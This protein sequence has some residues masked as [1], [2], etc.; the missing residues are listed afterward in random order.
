MLI[1]NDRLQPVMLLI[2][3][4]LG[5]LLGQINN[6]PQLAV[7]LVFPFL[8]LMLYALFLNIP[9]GQIKE[10]FQNKLFALTS[11]SINFIWTPILA[12][13]LGYF[14]LPDS[15]ALKIGFLMLMVTPCADWYLAF[16]AQA[17]GNLSLSTS[18][19]PANLL[20]QI[21]LLPTYLFLFSGVLGTFNWQILGHSILWGLAL[22]FLL[23][24][25]TRTIWPLEKY[26]G[27]GIFFK[28]AQAQFLN[29]AVMSM[30]AAE[31]YYLLK[32]PQSV[33]TLLLPVFCFFIITF[34]L[35]K[36]VASLLKFSYPDYVSLTMTT[37]ARNSPLA[38]A[39]AIISFPHEPLVHLALIVGPLLELPILALTVQ[40]LLFLRKTR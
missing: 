36:I 28:N 35:A 15:P 13:A 8:I 9:L 7:H 24:L 18:I 32:N 39:I 31:G 10:G 3:M 4:A 23:A 2:A 11:F 30:F 6:F 1:F 26:P 25:L 20:L 14:F 38:L 37:M 19:L 17:K 12:W 33:C 27:Y 22:P 5:L 16:T 40:A 34:I 29:L 21:L